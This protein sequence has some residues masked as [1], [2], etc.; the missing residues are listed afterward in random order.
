[1]QHFRLDTTRRFFHG[2]VNE[3]N[4]EEQGKRLEDGGRGCGGG[5]GGVAAGAAWGGGGGSRRRCGRGEFGPH[6]EDGVQGERQREKIWGG[7]DTEKEG[8]ESRGQEKLGQ[9]NDGEKEVTTLLKR[10]R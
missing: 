1:M 5:R 8:E 7:A 9:E 6:S 10:R 3:S 4:H 2:E